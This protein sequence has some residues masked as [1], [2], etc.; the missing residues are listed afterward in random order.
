MLLS[1]TVGFVRDLPH[2]LVASFK[3]TL[4]EAVHA[5]LLLHVLDVGH[6]R[7]QQQ[8][9]SVQGVLREIGAADKPQL[10]LLNKID[11]PDG[12]DN[13]DFWLA[14]RPDAIAIS[15]RGGLGIDDVARR[16]AEHAQGTLSQVRL[17]ANAADG[18]LVDFLERTTRVQDRH[19]DGDDLVM[20]T[21][22]TRR[23]LEQLRENSAVTLESV[24]PGPALASD[25]GSPAILASV[26]GD[27]PLTT[28]FRG[29]P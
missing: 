15:A 6:P 20:T 10:L 22:V 25:S 21:V 14:L 8:F 7:A 26:E 28:D 3:A 23:L 11:T 19:Y 24:G 5:D 27:L 16:V 29:S 17:R 1:D 13:A 12:H 18:R 2:N 9:D 4:E